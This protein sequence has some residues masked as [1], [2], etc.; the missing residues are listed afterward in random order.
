[1]SSSP[2]VLLPAPTQSLTPTPTSL[3]LLP[4]SLNIPSVPYTHPSLSQYFIPR[5]APPNSQIPTGT[6]IASFRGRQLVGQIISLPSAYRGLIVSVPPT[7]SLISF[8]STSNEPSDPDDN[9]KSDDISSQTNVRRSGRVKG[10]GQVALS[11]PKRGIVTRTKRYKLDSDTEEETDF[12]PNLIP[13]TGSSSSTTLK[14]SGENHND[15]DDE[16]GEGGIILRADMIN[17]QTPNKRRKTII[18]EIKVQE[19][20]PLK[21]PLPTPKKRLGVISPLKNMD[22]NQDAQLPNKS[23]D[24][25]SGKV[26]NKQISDVIM[27]IDIEDIGQTPIKDHQSD[28]TEMK[29]DEEIKEELI[30]SPGTEDQLPTFS[31]SPQPS[32]TRPSPLKAPITSESDGIPIELKV[33]EVIGK[34]EKKRDSS[35]RPGIRE[36]VPI[37]TFTSFILWTPDASLAGFRP[38]ELIP[39]S[40]SSNSAS[41]KQKSAD[42]DTSK[43]LGLREEGRLGQSKESTVREEVDHK[44]EGRVGEGEEEKEENRSDP[45]RDH[46]SMKGE[47][48][49]QDK[50]WWRT[51]G[52]G[53]G[54]DEVVRS[55]GEF[56]G[57]LEALHRPVYL[58][59]KRDGE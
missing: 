3:H 20:T 47:I 17:V 56:I 4:F 51:G 22:P 39:S 14:A 28:G 57:L 42:P 55:L 1:M 34:K 5:P 43:V 52:A 9:E 10:V 37:H 41:E 24:E 2:L 18:P 19:A 7:Q 31:L 15:N 35:G 45:A 16:E 13:G 25:V 30:P 21:N 54:G 38:D 46:I 48:A 11:R 6:P 50:G 58:H 49:S 8:S 59:R 29:L 33:D 36:L 26:E 23:D 12:S 53:E 32:T 27:H 44:I 40:D